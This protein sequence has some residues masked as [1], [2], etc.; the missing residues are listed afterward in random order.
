MFIWNRLMG[1][2]IKKNRNLDEPEEEWRQSNYSLKAQ[3]N[4]LP[5]L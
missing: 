1:N 3:Q 2:I 4:P 5:S